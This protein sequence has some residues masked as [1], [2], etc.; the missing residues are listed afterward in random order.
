MTDKLI[1]FAS[2]AF[3]TIALATG[4]LF[5]KLVVIVPIMGWY[6]FGERTAPSF[7]FGVAFIALGI[8]L[9]QYANREF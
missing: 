7:W 9:T 1:N 2:L 8:L 6:R 3:F 5:F 4:Q